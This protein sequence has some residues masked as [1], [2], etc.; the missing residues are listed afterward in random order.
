MLVLSTLLLHSHLSLRTRGGRYACFQLLH[1]SA[2]NGAR[3]SAAA[4]CDCDGRA[5]FFRAGPSILPGLRLAFLPPAFFQPGS[6]ERRRASIR[7]RE[8]TCI[9][10]RPAAPRGGVHQ[11]PESAGG[12][13]GNGR[14]AIGAIPHRESRTAGRLAPRLPRVQAQPH[15]DIH[16][17]SE[18]RGRREGECWF[19][20]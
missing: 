2:P 19:T 13:A 10:H 12:R 5:T 16:C 8:R 7:E 3:C 6:L 17:D 11:L 15:P 20:F 9:R 18:D 4:A 1:A 14:A